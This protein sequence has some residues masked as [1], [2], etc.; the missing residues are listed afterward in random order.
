MTIPIGYTDTAVILAAGRGTRLGGIADDL[1]KG[2]LPALDKTF[3]T[4]A[5]GILLGAGIADIVI[6]TGHGAEH[7]DRLCADYP[8]CVRTLY[9]PDFAHMGTMRSLSVALNAL[10]GPFLVLDADIVYEARA[11]HSIVAEPFENAIVISA[12]GDLGDEFLAWGGPAEGPGNRKLAHLSKQRSARK[13]APDGE[14][15]GIMKI[16]K[17]LASAMRAWTGTHPDEAAQWPYEHCILALLEQHP[18]SMVHLPTLVWTE[19]DT[20]EML[21]HA[22]RV[23]LPRLAGLDAG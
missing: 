1:P 23:I 4:R 12:I 13:E 10:S 8:G 2:F 20:V 6:V 9:N 21:D 14:H 15:M 5:I 16:G 11:V 7:Y 22:S 19:V 18:L 17:S 3:I